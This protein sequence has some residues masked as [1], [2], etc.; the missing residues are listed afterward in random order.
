MSYILFSI[1]LTFLLFKAR[2]GHLL[3]ILL[4]I[5]LVLG[6]RIGANADYLNYYEYWSV[7]ISSSFPDLFKP[8]P[9]TLFLLLNK[10]F[11]SLN[12]SFNFFSFFVTFAASISTYIVYIATRFRSSFLVTIPSLVFVLASTQLRQSL[13]ISF[14]IIGFY[15]LQ[16]LKVKPLF[17]FSTVIV[18]LSSFLHF[19]A[20]IFLPLIFFLS[21]PL[22]F[23]ETIKYQLKSLLRL[24]I[25]YT[26]SSKFLFFLAAFPF[27]LSYVL[28]L[29]LARLLYYQDNTLAVTT[30]GTLYRL[31]PLNIIFLVSFYTCK[32]PLLSTFKI[33]NIFIGSVYLL[34][35]NDLVFFISPVTADRL[36]F[37]VYP[38]L[39]FY[40]SKSRFGN[41][42]SLS[43]FAM[44]SLNILLGSTFES[45]RQSTHLF[46]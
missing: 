43:I 36:T 38:G 24:K 44:F 4:L 37:F 25:P 26:I 16:K 23:A 17:I 27:I 42:L 13:A 12:L 46:L 1:A 3:F 41:M 20:L 30:F 6:F 9:F 10:L 14:L 28:P 45:A 40:L 22:D 39:C 11:S 5:S 7:A 32:A 18:F 35:F 8:G 31:V 2:E 21:A 29:A 19:S 34:L 15:L 33:L